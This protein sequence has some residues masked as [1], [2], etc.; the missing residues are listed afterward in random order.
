M[1]HGQKNI[2]LSST[3]FEHSSVHPQEDLHM[4]FY[5]IYFKRP[6]QSGRWQDLPQDEHL[7]VRNMSKTL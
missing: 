3:C 4:R 5:V 7:Y 6:K 2:K 1:M